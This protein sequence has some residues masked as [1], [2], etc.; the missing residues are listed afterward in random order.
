MV[1]AAAIHCPACR[2]TGEAVFERGGFDPLVEL[3]AWIER[4]AGGA[5]GDE[6][7][8]LEQAASADVADVPVRDKYVRAGKLPSPA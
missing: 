7:D 1:A 6:L 3:E 4:L 5:I 8:G 2:I